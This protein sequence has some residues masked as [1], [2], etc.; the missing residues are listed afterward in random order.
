MGK[1]AKAKRHKE[2][3]NAKRA[4]KAREYEA[5]KGTGKNK[6]NKSYKA[7]KAVSPEKVLMLVSV[8][9]A[10][11]ATKAERRVHGGPEC[12]NVGCKRCSSVWLN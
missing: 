2:K 7:K 10:G 12:G 8:V 4:E 6:L 1:R 5:L 9:I 3:M 11:Q